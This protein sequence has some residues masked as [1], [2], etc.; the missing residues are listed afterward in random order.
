MSDPTA[1]RYFED[2]TAYGLESE[3]E[4]AVLRSQTECTF[5]W[6][7]KDGWPMGVIM[8]FV[9][10]DGRFWLTAS[11]H[12][13]R[14]SA[15]RREPRVAIVVSSAGSAIEPGRSV[16]YRGIC[17]VHDDDETKRWFYPALGLRRFPDDDAYR[18]QFV[19]KLDSPRRVVLEVTPGERIGFDAERMHGRPGEGRRA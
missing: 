1:S 16:T 8:S 11:S 12:R 4:A 14:V 10:R 15:V 3:R 7:T 17:R 9:H 5:V 13:G 18:E 2:L 6:S 19:E